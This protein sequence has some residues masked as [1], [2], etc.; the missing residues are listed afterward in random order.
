[1]ASIT[2]V[3]V[4]AIGIAALVAAGL[5]STRAAGAAH[6]VIAPQLG[7]WT[8]LSGTANVESGTPAIWQDLQHRATILWEHRDSSAAFTYDVA[9][10]SPTGAPGATMDAFAGAHWGSLSNEPT[11][12]GSVEGVPLVV[13]DGIQGVKGSYA[14]GCIYGAAATTQPWTLESWSLSNGCANPTGSAGENKFATPAAAWPGTHSVQ[15]RIGTSQTIPATGPDSSIPLAA[16]GTAY[17][18]GVAADTAGSDDFYIAWAQTFSTPATHDGYYV[19]DVTSGSAA[20]KAPGSDT[21]SINRLGQFSNLAITARAGHPGVYVA[22]CTSSTKCR[23]KLWHVGPANAMSLPGTPNPGSVSISSGPAGR[24]WVAWFDENTLKVYVTRTNTK[25]SRFGPVR[26]YSTP[27]AEHG[28]L[29]LSGGSSG[30]LDVALQCVRKSNLKLVELSTQVEVALRVS[31]SATRVSNTSAHTIT[32]T[33]T[34]VG[35]AVAGAKVTFRGSSKT[36]NSNGKAAFTLP[37]HTRPGTYT[38]TASKS[39]YLRATATVKVTT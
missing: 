29:G 18:T 28:L 1:M 12:L 36:T 14:L 24:I 30:R 31:A 11:L 25:V 20:V 27:C 2:R 37:K 26:S 5:T 22:Y 16:N 15:Y 6:H 3:G 21:N 4:A 9:K 19:K 39:Q 17:K 38:V 35:D 33:V 32:M 7:H 8:S 13:F 10:I 34:D 23:L